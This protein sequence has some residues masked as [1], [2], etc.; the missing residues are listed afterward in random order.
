MG[1]KLVV[2]LPDERSEGRALEPQTELGDAALEQFLV[3]Q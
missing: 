3:A 1:S 2:K